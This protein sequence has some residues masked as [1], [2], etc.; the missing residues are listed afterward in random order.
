MVIGLYC[1]GYFLGSLPF[2]YWVSKAFGIDILKVG[3]GNTGATN[4]YRQL[5]PKGGV[6]VF[7]LDVAKGFVPV[8]L[9]KALLVPSEASM[10]A[11]LIGVAAVVGHSFSPFLKFK[12][13]KGV[14]TGLGVVLGIAPIVG[15]TGFAS[16][17]ACLA[18]S[19]YV[20]LSSI[21]GTLMVVVTAILTKQSP[22]V[23]AVLS[24]VCAF[25]IIRHVPNIK[26]LINGTEPKVKRKDGTDSRN[27]DNRQGGGS[28][29]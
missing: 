9:A 15:L 28:D 22:L 12:G 13:G 20:S 5:G 7:L 16:F 8:F 10:H 21:V 4:V 2:G 3:S 25:V 17:L 23:L 18:V 19:R 14:A 29:K 1:L 11:I 26:R 27:H 24:L 6:M